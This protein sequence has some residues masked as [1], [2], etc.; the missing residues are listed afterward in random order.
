L[1]DERRSKVWGRVVVKMCG[2]SLR[3]R[4]VGVQGGEGMGI[5]HNCILVLVHN[6]G[7]T[8][9][10]FKRIRS[11]FRLIGSLPSSNK[12]VL[13]SLFDDFEDRYQPGDA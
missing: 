5:T 10:S 2:K 7:A 6:A 9:Q 11:S 3:K 13:P 12:V 8:R 1:R 4:W